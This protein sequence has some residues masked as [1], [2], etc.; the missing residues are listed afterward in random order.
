MPDG[1]DIAIGNLRDAFIE[2]KQRISVCRRKG[3]DTKIS[4]LRM[5]SVP[6]KI[7][8]V[9]ATRDFRDVQKVNVMISQSRSEVEEIEH[10]MMTAEKVEEEKV[11]QEIIK[12]EEMMDDL[13]R[14]IKAGDAQKAKDYYLQCF[15]IYNKLESKNKLKVIQKLT[16]LREVLARM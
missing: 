7:K 13:D 5:S 1:I 4:E 6:A 10:Q 8:M 9:E 3:L 2:L 11:D 16:F 15:N 12:M 14:R